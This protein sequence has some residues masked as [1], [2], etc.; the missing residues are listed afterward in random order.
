MSGRHRDIGRAFLSGYLKRKAK[1]DKDK[2]DE[3]VVAKSRK[4][5]EF[6]HQNS[7]NRSFNE[8]SELPTDDPTRSWLDDTDTADDAV[9][10]ASAN[11]MS[12]ARDDVYDFSTEQC[13]STN[14]KI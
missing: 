8:D 13:D 14:D 10:E 12:A 7:V 9:D 1:T 4:V 3:A 6:F 2:K 11:E 5:T